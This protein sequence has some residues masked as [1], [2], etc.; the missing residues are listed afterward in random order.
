MKS[1]LNKLGYTIIV[2]F[3]CAYGAGCTRAT[4]VIYPQDTVVVVNGKAIT[5]QD[6]KDETTKREISTKIL[7]KIKQLDSSAQTPT[8][9]V[10]LLLGLSESQL[11]EDQKRYIASMERDY[12]DKPISQNV[13]FNRIVREEVLHQE[14]VMQGYIVSNEQAQEIITQMNEASDQA[15]SSDPTGQKIMAETNPIFKEYGFNSQD[16]YLN[17]NLPKT[18]RSMSIQRIQNKLDEKMAAQYTE[19]SDFLL[20]IAQYNAWEDYTEFLL[21]TAKIEI[22]QGNYVVE[23]YGKIWEMGRLD[24]K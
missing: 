13:I 21:K 16:D 6:F 20:R 1:I 9:G 18:A 14:A 10:L 24:L 23:Y 22:K 7:Q 4:Q 17:W 5:E 8:A 11:S 15:N 2:L 19:L 3:I 12:P